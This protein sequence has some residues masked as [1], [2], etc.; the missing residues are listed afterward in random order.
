MKIEHPNLVIESPAAGH[1]IITGLQS[2]STQTEEGRLVHPTAVHISPEVPS[3]VLLAIVEDRKTSAVAVPLAGDA[4]DLIVAALQEKP[5]R[6]GDLSI[7][8]GVPTD[9]IKSLAGSR[10]EIAGGWA[11]VVTPEPKEVA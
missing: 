7:K 8:T 3:E 1:Y 2:G 10:F 9:D 11:K 6:V 4:E 5:L